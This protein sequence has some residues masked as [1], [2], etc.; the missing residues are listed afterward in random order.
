MPTANICFYNL[1][2]ADSTVLHF[3]PSIVF[4]EIDHFDHTYNTIFSSFRINENPRTIERERGKIDGENLVHESPNLTVLNR[5][6]KFLKLFASR[7]LSRGRFSNLVA[8]GGQF[9]APYFCPELI[10]VGTSHFPPI[11]LILLINGVEIL[12]FRYQSR[13]FLCIC[14]RLVYK[15]WFEHFVGCYMGYNGWIH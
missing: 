6:C 15:S 9:R 3:G 5:N 14:V 10:K 4:N 8:V 13:D 7:I 12:D 11:H 2:Q 1:V